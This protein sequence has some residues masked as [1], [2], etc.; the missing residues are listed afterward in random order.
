MSDPQN[1]GEQQDTEPD[2]HGDECYGIDRAPDG[3]YRT[4]DGRPI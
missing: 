2:T 1:G 4:C 3:D